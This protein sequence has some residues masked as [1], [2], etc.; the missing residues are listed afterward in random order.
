M[1]SVVQKIGFGSVALMVFAVLAVLWF[2]VGKSVLGEGVPTVYALVVLLVFS[3]S[4]TLNGF[5]LWKKEF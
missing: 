1:S 3:V 5:L 4:F 2:F